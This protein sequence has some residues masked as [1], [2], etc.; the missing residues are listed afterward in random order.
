MKRF[1]F[2]ICLVAALGLFL[3]LSVSSDT[4]A[5]GTI[6]SPSP[7]RQQLEVGDSI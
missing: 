3:L 5:A 4:F 1:L 7:L 6:S 2:L